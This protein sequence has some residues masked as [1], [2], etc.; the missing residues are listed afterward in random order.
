MKR[1]EGGNHHEL[2]F[3]L[4]LCIISSSEVKKEF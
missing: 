2:Y 4:N 3:E 1:G